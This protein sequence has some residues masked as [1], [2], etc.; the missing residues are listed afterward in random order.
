MREGNERNYVTWDDVT[1][2][3]E[4]LYK[5]YGMLAVMELHRIVGLNGKRTTCVQF[6]YDKVGKN[7]GNLSRRGKA[8][9]WPCNNHKSLAGL[10]LFLLHVDEDE[11]LKKFEAEQ[12]P[13]LEAVS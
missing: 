5:E 6:K 7:A 2:A 3:M 4:H 11:Y 9:R 10:A 8:S 1:I 12:L 13:L